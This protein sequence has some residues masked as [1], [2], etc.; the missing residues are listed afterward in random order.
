MLLILVW[1]NDRPAID[2]KSVVFRNTTDAQLDAV[3]QPS[4]CLSCA[5]QRL[6][7]GWRQ[8]VVQLRMAREPRVPERNNAKAKENGLP[9]WSPTHL[10]THVPMHL[11][12]P[13][14]RR[15]LGASVQVPR[16]KRRGPFTSPADRGPLPLDP[17]AHLAEGL[18]LHWARPR[19]LLGPQA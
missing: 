8:G 15:P 7:P 3:L 13:F 2:V 17:R 12:W 14:M 16:P 6:K 5:V 9:R 19:P 4:C 11:P 18:A 1:Q 10:A